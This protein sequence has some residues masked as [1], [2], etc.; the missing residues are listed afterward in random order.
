[1]TFR[2]FLFIFSRFGGN[3]GCLTHGFNKGI[4]KIGQ[5]SKCDCNSNSYLRVHKFALTVICGCGGCDVGAIKIVW[6]AAS[7]P[8]REEAQWL[9]DHWVVL[10]LS[11]HYPAIILYTILHTFVLNCDLLHLTVKLF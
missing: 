7:F 11:P 4:V 5:L 9:E 6:I 8:G 2:H 1:M 10:S 3:Y